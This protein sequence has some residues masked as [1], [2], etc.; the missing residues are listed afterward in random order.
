MQTASHLTPA[1]RSSIPPPNRISLV[2]PVDGIQIPRFRSPF[3]PRNF[4][5]CYIS[6]MPIREEDCQI[7]IPIDDGSFH[8]ASLETFFEAAEIT[9]KS[10]QESFFSK[11]FGMHGIRNRRAFLWRMLKQRDAA[12]FQRILLNI[13]LA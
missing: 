1:R 5:G 3:P 9:D 13:G 12:T 4:Q 2:P 8:V 10:E 6:G 11:F 7:L